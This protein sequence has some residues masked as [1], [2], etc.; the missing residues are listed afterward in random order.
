LQQWRDLQRDEMVPL[1][2]ESIALLKDI[3]YKTS[4]HPVAGFGGA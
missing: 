2:D 4:N 3:Y 1:L